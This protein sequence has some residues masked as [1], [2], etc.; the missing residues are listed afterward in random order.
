MGDIF[1]SIKQVATKP[2]SSSSF[3]AA[4]LVYPVATG[5]LAKD[6]RKKLSKKEAAALK[7]DVEASGLSSAPSDYPPNYLTEWK[8]NSGGYD[9]KTWL[10]LRS[11]ESPEMVDEVKAY[12]LEK[13]GVPLEQDMLNRTLQDYVYPSLEADKANK[14]KAQQIVASYQPGMDASRKL[15]TDMLTTDAQ[16]NSALLNRDLAHLDEARGIKLTAAE[17]QAAARQAA[18]GTSQATRQA[19]LGTAVDERQA[20]LDTS[21]EARQAALGTAVDERQSA[22]DASQATRLDA[23]TAELGSRQAALAAL[24]QERLNAADGQAT[25]INLA[26][27][28]ESDQIA[29]NAAAQGFI[30][31]SSFQDGQLARSLINARQGAAGVLGATKVANETDNRSLS[32]YGSSQTRALTDYG[33]T[34]GR[35]IADFGATGKLNLADFGATE[36]RSIADFGTTGRLNL[37]DFGATEGRSIA[38]QEAANK[39]ATE[40]WYGTGKLGYY[41]DDNKLRLANLNTPLLNATAE[42]GLQKSVNDAGWDGLTRSLNT[43]DWWKTGTAAPAAGT[44]PADQTTPSWAAALGPSLVNAGLQLGVNNL[45]KSPTTTPAKT[46]EGS[47]LYNGSYVNT[48]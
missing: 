16:G 18:L 36:G 44:A 7:A 35:S 8:A 46:P 13:N 34:E 38:D 31:G 4:T 47:Y 14:L 28:T 15:V 33:A 42:L 1:K 48:G 5:Q 21:L 27:Q 45:S 11:Q 9:F 3:K 12:Q 37:A 22:L 19:A 41:A 39:Y 25:A 10:Y 20:S 26:Q 43:L 32:D 6:A 29:A 17:E 24:N 23:L 40:D 2:F 30:G